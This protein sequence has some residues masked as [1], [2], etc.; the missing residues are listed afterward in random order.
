MGNFSELNNLKAEQSYMGRYFGIIE[1]WLNRVTAA[2]EK[3]KQNLYYEPF[4]EEHSAAGQNVPKAFGVS[5]SLT[6]K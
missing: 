6:Y 3:I 2:Q 1:F 4:F 5:Y